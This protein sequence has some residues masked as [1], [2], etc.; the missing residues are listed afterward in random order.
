V[1]TVI[2]PFTSTAHHDKMPQLMDSVTVLLRPAT[3]RV[4]RGENQIQL[5]VTDARFRGDHFDV[6][7]ETSDQVLVRF[8]TTQQVFA[9]DS[10]R[11]HFPP[12]NV[13]VL[14]E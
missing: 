9:G 10:M 8:H 12:N 7:G 14:G 1:T 11:I 13:Q 3:A 5:R 2:G 4:G 6:R